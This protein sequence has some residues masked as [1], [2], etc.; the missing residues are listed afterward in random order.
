MDMK[1]FRNTINRNTIKHSALTGLAALAL[2]CTP[3]SNP[4]PV[5]PTPTPELVISNLTLKAQNLDNPGSTD[6][7][8]GDRTQYTATI[9]VLVKNPTTGMNAAT[10]KEF[11]YRFN[12]SQPA[13]DVYLSGNAVSN[14]NNVSIINAPNVTSPTA[15]TLAYNVVV[16]DPTNNITG[17]RT[18]VGNGDTMNLKPTQS[19]NYVAA[20]ANPNITTNMTPMSNL[21]STDF[22]NPGNGAHLTPAQWTTILNA[23]KDSQGVET[24]S[25]DTDFIFSVYRL[26]TSD[27][28]VIVAKTDRR[29]SL[30]TLQKMLIAPAQTAQSAYTS[31]K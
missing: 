28:N 15:N 6:Y 29:S 31:D 8:T 20:V 1:N 3:S 30:Y 11:D 12:P 22:Y 19:F 23:G 26:N 14:F 17:L 5:P 13:Y 4:D 16:N 7:M 27:G 18:I 2:A 10:V 21:L 24:T 25:Y 9:D